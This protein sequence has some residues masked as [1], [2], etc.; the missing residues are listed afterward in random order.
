RD[1]VIQNGNRIRQTGESYSITFHATTPKGDRK[2][3]QERGYGVKDADG[4]VVSLFGTVQDITESKITE[5]VIKNALKEKETILESIGDGFYAVDNNWIITYWNEKATQLLGRTREE[6]LGQN[7]WSAYPDLVDSSFYQK[8]SQALT[9]R[10]TLHFEG[11]Y[12]QMN[13][14]YEVS[15]YP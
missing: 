8:Y 2:V 4:N 14:W 12:N 5:E 7:L 15:V 1:M 11:F 10:E 9:H 13:T 3:I 6:L